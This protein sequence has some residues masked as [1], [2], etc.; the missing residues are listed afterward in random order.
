[1]KLIQIEFVEFYS[2]FFSLDC[3][4]EAVQNFLRIEDNNLDFALEFVDIA[5][6]EVAVFHLFVLDDSVNIERL[7]AS[8]EAE[9]EA[10]AEAD[11]EDYTEERTA[12]AEP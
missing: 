1:M 12:V 9:A 3:K 5:D 2:N 7:V 10:E 6:A 8:F 11:I 4:A